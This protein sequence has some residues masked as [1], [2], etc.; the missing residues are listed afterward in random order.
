MWTGDYF[1]LVRKLVIKDFTIRYRHMSLGIFWSLLNPLVMM[2]VWTY[3]FTTIFRNS[4][5]HFPLHILSGVITFNFFTVAWQSATTSVLDNAGLIKRNPFRRE[6][7]PIASILSNVPHL[8]IQLGLLVVFVFIGGLGMNIHWLWLPVVWGLELLCL[9]GL[10]LA[11]SAIYVVV[12]DMRYIVES[13]NLVLFWV[14]PIVYS[15]DM[16]PER[17]RPLYQFNPIAALILATHNIVLQG[18]SPSTILLA[19]LAAVSVISM[20][21]GLIIFRRVERKF[22]EYL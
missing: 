19:K 20:V 21:L 22:Y 16:V 18:R 11:C 5:P 6:V 12:R 13:I 17:M 7:I 9:I 15:F 10:G 2:A 4:I 14:V 1:Y 3:V 8:L